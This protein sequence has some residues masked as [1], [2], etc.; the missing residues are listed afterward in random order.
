MAIPV[1]LL[2]QIRDKCN[3]GNNKV[4]DESCGKCDSHDQGETPIIGNMCHNMNAEAFTIA[5][6]K[7]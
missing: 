2:L 3:N 4:V 7:D 6:I 5:S 1:Q